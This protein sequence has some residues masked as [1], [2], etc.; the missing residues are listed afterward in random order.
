M[1]LYTV[2]NLNCFYLLSEKSVESRIFFCGNRSM[3]R[4]DR[5]H[6]NWGSIIPPTGPLKKTDPKKNAAK[7]WHHRGWLSRRI[8]NE[9]KLGKW[10]T[11]KRNNQMFDLL[12][13]FWLF[14][15]ISFVHGLYSQFRTSSSV[16]PTVTDLILLF[17]NVHFRTHH[18]VF[19]NSSK[20]A[21]SF[22]MISLSFSSAFSFS[23]SRVVSSIGWLKSILIP[24]DS[25]TPYWSSPPSS[26]RKAE[27]TRYVSLFLLCHRVK[28]FTRLLK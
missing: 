14:L 4:M 11:V 2:G 9:K 23:Y 24:G 26:R 16:R 19:I 15:F 12:I 3:N 13:S 5:K 21:C 25:I 20:T 17:H 28:F 7:T 10:F 18:V 27:C 8:S 6:N 22:F 1:K